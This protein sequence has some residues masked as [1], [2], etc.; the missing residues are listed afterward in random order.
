MMLLALLLSGPALAVDLPDFS[1]QRGVYDAAFV[2]EVSPTEADATV[3]CSTDRTAPATPCTA[4]DIT[5]TSVVR[6]QQVAADGS[7]SLVATHTYVFPQDVLTSAVMN[8]TITGNAAYAANIDST[9]RDLPILSLVLQSGVSATE[10]QGSFEWIDPTGDVT[11]VDCGVREVG[12]TAT[13]YAK[14]TLRLN[15]RSRYGASRLDAD[16]Y[17]GDYTGVAPTDSF[18]SL[19][20]R[21]GSHDSVFYL[22]QKGQYLRNPWMDESQLAMGHMAPHGRQGHLFING[23]YVGLYHVRERFGASFLASY[24]GGD[25]DDYEAINANRVIAGSGAAW[26]AVTDAYGD[27]EEVS[28][29][30][31]AANFLDYMILN[32]YGANDWDWNPEQNWMSAGPSDRTQG[33]YVFHASD[34]DICLYYGWDENILDEVGLVVR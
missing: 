27:W 5:G 15:F 22:G 34:N 18:D 29:G 28:L 14:D 10:Q 24:L 13:A 20:L 6:A 8:A 4:V 2:L 33:G 3:L 11:Q 9:L 30:I 32:F 1:A 26:S 7:T 17:G 12:G 31:D 21:S 25:E 19:T 23:T 16:L